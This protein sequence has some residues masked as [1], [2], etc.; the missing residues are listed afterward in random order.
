MTDL[1]IEAYQCG[2]QPDYRTFAREMV[3]TILRFFED[4]ENERAYREWKEAREHGDAGAVS[5]LH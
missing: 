5:V 4:P 2:T 1:R 3:D